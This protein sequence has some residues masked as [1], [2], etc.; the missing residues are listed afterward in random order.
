MRGIYPMDQENGEFQCGQ[1]WRDLF[2]EDNRFNFW[3]DTVSM[4]I[5]H[6]SDVFEKSLERD[7]VLFAYKRARLSRNLSR[8]LEVEADI[9]LLNNA[10]TAFKHQVLKKG[11]L[12][13]SRD[14]ITRRRFEKEVYTK[15]LDIKPFMERFNEVR[16]SA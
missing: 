14:D 9:S 1:Y 12:I 8:E 7:G 11:K 6:V 13:Y 2:A 10:S 15:Y 16:K 3:I 4:D 5:E